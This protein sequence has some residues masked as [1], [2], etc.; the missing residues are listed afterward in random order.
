[1]FMFMIATNCLSSTGGFN[2]DCTKA[3]YWARLCYTA[4]FTTYIYNILL[5]IKY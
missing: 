3:C 4:I 2:V 1:M 5:F